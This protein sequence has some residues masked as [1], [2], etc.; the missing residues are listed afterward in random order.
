MLLC[1]V[2]CF[3]VL[4]VCC[5]GLDP[6]GG[7]AFEFGQVADAAFDLAD[8]AGGDV[9]GV[10]DLLLGDAVRGTQSAE[11]SPAFGG[12][13]VRG[14]RAATDGDER[15]VRLAR[16]EAF[17]APDD[18][19]LAFAFPGLPVHVVAGGLV[20]AHAGYGDVVQGGVAPAI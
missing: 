11:P 1:I 10:A 16:D 5:D 14:Y 8:A 9:E 18:L 12:R 7:P 4:V 13:F 20:V 15:V 2:K 3:V 6:L 17:E 19:E